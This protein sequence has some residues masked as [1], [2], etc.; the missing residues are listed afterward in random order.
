MAIREC[1]LETLGL[2]IVDSLPLSGLKK[3]KRASFSDH[4]GFFSRLFCEKTLK[5]EGFLKSVSQIN[6]SVT[7]KK[8]SIR[9]LHAQYPPHAEMKLVT[10]LSGK[11][12]DVAV[13][14]RKNSPTFLKWYATILSEENQESLLIPEGFAHGFQSLSD[15]TCLIYCHS[16]GYEPSFELRLHP[17]DPAL[18]I[19][20]PLEVQDLSKKDQE[21]AFIGPQFEGM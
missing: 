21:A 7:L 18:T 17:Q 2:M 5:T 4:R 15:N 12:W 8:G 16:H 1:P 19:N 6:H 13:D 3:I 9:G 20:W 10:C 11:I 14:I